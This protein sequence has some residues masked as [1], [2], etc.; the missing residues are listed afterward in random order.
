MK[1]DIDALQASGLLERVTKVPRGVESA[2]DAARAQR[3]DDSSTALPGVPLLMQRLIRTGAEIPPYWSRARDLFLEKLAVEDDYLPGVLSLATTKLASIPI[4]I[5]PRDPTI[6]TH[7]RQ[8]DAMTD[9]LL[10]ASQY[11][12][13]YPEF[14][15]LFVGSYLAQDNGAFAE[16]IS[17]G[18]KD[19]PPSGPFLG[20]R[21][22]PSL[23]VTRTGHPKWPIIVHDPH[24]GRQKYHWTRIIKMASMPSRR[25]ELNGVG[26]CA[27]SRSIAVAR[28]LTYSL[29]HK[30][31]KKGARARNEMLIGKN[32]TA[33]EMLQ[34]IALSDLMIDDLG[35]EYYAQVIAIGG[36][37][38]DV[39]RISVNDMGDY[40][41][42]TELETG[43]YALAMIWNLEPVELFPLQGTKSSDTIAL[44]RSRSKL[45]AIFIN[46]FIAQSLKI[47]PPHLKV[48]LDYV[49][50]ELDMRA[51]NIEDIQSRSTT[52]NIENG[53]LTYR[54]ARQ[55]MR[56]RGA[57]SWPQYVNMELEAGRTA[58]GVPVMSR[59]YDPN[60]ADL[61]TVPDDI[62][63]PTARDY[64]EA[65]SLIVQNEAFLHQ[66]IATAGRSA[67]QRTRALEVL[68]ALE[69]ADQRLR[70]FF[71]HRFTRA[72]EGRN[73]SPEVAGPDGGQTPGGVDNVTPE[74]GP[75]VDQA[76]PDDSKSRALKQLAPLND[77]RTSDEMVGLMAAIDAGSAS[78][79]Q[80]AF[81][82]ALEAAARLALGALYEGGDVPDEYMQYINDEIT[83]MNAA[84][85]IGR[86][87]SG[88]DMSATKGRVAAAIERVFWIIWLLVGLEDGELYIWLYGDTVDHCEDCARLENQVHTRADW[89]R[90]ASSTGLYPRSTGLACTG[91]FCD[92]GLY[93][94]S[95]PETM[96]GLA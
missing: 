72:T 32:I 48:V 34:A 75:Q 52:R 21:H 93:P 7:M 26:V 90:Y 44:Q 92:C 25:R 15:Q 28:D 55:L 38:V 68:R 46:Q 73:P 43:M 30:A 4:R 19:K 14:A 47:V 70:A 60:Y 82:A 83:L 29:R 1:D 86:R 89:A 22:I 76:P 36:Q 8:A 51:A 24:E 20:L 67:T 54:V 66:H 87:E 58:E 42:A 78:A 63:D 69:I 71:D 64:R 94:T 35:L 45:P 85:L 11:G 18:P 53:T 96:G 17:E 77:L 88:V 61:V 40:D 62:L 13:G 31:E 49:D 74:A 27:L 41:F 16:I 5:E 12:D 81:L 33:A 6:A 57:V 39:K 59:L 80:S 56:D 50:D 2:V 84:E 65:V 9:I 3:F 95:K 91:R 37:D 79:L 10:S 23:D